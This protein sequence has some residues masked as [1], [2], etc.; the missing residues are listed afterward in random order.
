ML[1]LLRQRSMRLDV[2]YS[3]DNPVK[4]RYVALILTDVNFLRG[5][6]VKWRIKI[7]K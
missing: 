4:N 5:Y 6:T 2:V 7:V 1:M 3:R